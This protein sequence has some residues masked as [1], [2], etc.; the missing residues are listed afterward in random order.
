MRRNLD[1]ATL[2]EKLCL[3]YPQAYPADID[4][5]SKFKRSY[6]N[7]VEGTAPVM[8]G[9]IFGLVPIPFAWL[10]VYALI[11]IWRWIKRGFNT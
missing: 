9:A 10:I 7:L 5:A 3:E 2:D 4:C 6:D 11:G 1:M 8:N